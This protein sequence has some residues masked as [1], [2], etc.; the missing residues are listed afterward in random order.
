M[1]GMMLKSL[2]YFRFRALLYF[3]S[4]IACMSLAQ[5]AL[6][7]P[8]DFPPPPDAAV[9]WVG[10]NIEVNG[11]KSSIR[12]FHTGDSIEE[13][14]EFYRREWKK[15]VEKGKPGFMETIDAA[16]WYII[17]RVED[18][19]LLTV[20]V[21][22]KQNDESGAWGYLSISPLP[23]NNN[24]PAQLGSSTPKM[25]G[26]HVVNEIKSKDPG[27]TATTLIIANDRSIESNVAFYRNHYQ[28]RGWT[29]ETDYDAQDIHTL[30]FKTRR[31]RVTIMLLKDGADT[32]IVVNSVTNSLF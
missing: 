16:P 5:S 8:P 25:S 20:Q 27:K 6:A 14:V 21:Q 13:V 4:V 24:K 11:I 15:P 22:V 31:E 10:K 9:E 30:V 17:S 12:A 29:T 1:Q 26:S 28:G 18:G 32:R 2:K 19:Y 23:G 7:G 3:S